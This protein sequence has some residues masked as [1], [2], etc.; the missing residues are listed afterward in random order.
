MEL[1]VLVD[2]DVVYIVDVAIVVSIVGVFCHK[3]IMIMNNQ[4]M[5]VT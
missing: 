5:I 3:K 4:R 1:V 2:V